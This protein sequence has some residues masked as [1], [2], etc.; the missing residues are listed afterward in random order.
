MKIISADEAAL[1]IND[2]C[3]IALS[4]SAATSLVADRVLRAIEERY[5]SAGT[6]KDLTVFHPQGM[7][8]KTLREC[9]VLPIRGCV[10][11]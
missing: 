7:G 4:G 3:T 10:K 6:P 8:D 11:E 2:E 5:L 9:H 1:L